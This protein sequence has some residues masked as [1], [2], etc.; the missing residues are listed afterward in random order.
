MTQVFGDKGLGRWKK[1]GGSQAMSV[2][3]LGEDQCG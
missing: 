1:E 3:I 2:S